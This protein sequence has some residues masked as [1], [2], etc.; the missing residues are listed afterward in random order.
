VSR[1]FRREIF[2][3]VQAGDIVALSAIAHNRL[4]RVEADDERRS[5]QAEKK[6]NQRRV[7]GQVGMSRTSPLVPGRPGTSWDVPG[8]VQQH[9][10]TDNNNKAVHIPPPSAQVIAKLGDT[11]LQSALDRLRDL[12]GEQWEDVAA[13]LL[14]RKYVSWQG[15]VDTM[16]R[17]VG[18]TSQFT[19]DDLAQVCRDDPTL[20]KPIG[21]AYALRTFL[22]YA[23]IERMRPRE[24]PTNGRPSRAAVNGSAKQPDVGAEMFGRICGL[25]RSNPDPRQGAVR[26]IPMDE[27]KKLGDSAMR[28]YKAIGGASR[29]IHVVINTPEKLH[30]LEQDF[31]K[32]Y[33]R[34]EAEHAVH[35]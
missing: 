2:D 11:K 15:W 30:F 20:D 28:A 10:S 27:V 26:F 31:S 29:V 3:A 12:M 5:R 19:P 21:S 7:P 35:V 34:L 22:G 32:E 6:R 16:L 33:A 24:P 17:E 8:V 4:G 14:R 13:F 1:D 23:R 9:L 18:M 25:V